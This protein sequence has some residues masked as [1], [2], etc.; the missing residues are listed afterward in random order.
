MI[1]ERFMG[2]LGDVCQLISGQ[3]INSSDYNT[4]SRAGAAI[5]GIS[6][7]QVLG[8]RI[9]L[10][11]LSE[12][13]RIVGILDKAFAAIATAKANTEKNLQN[14]RAL[15]DSQ[16]ETIFTQN[17][18]VCESRSLVELTERITKGSSPRWQGIRYVDL[19]GVLFVTSENVSDFDVLIKDPKYVE[20]KFNLKDGKSILKRGDVLTNIVGASIGRTAIFNL[21]AT[22]N[23]NQAVCLIRCNPSA[24]DNGYLTCLLNSPLFKQ[25]LHDNEVNTARANLSL[26]FF[27]RLPV[28]LPPLR[29]QKEIAKEVGRLRQLVLDTQRFVRDKISKLDELKRSL[30]H[31]AFNG[32]L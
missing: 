20:E 5:P 17:A 7:E 11:S 18:A 24:L 10:P 12:Q 6:R 8:L 26:S 32:H 9:P 25:V 21:D 1:A 30:L 28:P 22:A 27:S 14:A 31:E 16:L 4:S 3:H 29:R 2:A 13:Q 23:I 19:P 15:F